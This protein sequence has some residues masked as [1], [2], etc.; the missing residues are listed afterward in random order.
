MILS[1]PE[2]SLLN[3]NNDPGR[4]LAKF[5]REDLLYFREMSFESSKQQDSIAVWLVG[6][7]TASIALIVSQAGKF[8]PNLQPVLKITV[9]CLSATI[10]FGLLFRIFHLFL[11]D[12]EH[13]D[14]RGISGFL[15]AYSQP[16]T[17]PIEL[18]EDLS[19]E[20]IAEFLYVH[21]GYDFRHYLT[22]D[23]DTEFWRD[24]YS[25]LA[26][27]WNQSHKDAMES[28]FSHIGRAEGL[29]EQ[30]VEQKLKREDPARGIRKRR[31]KRLCKALYTFM[32][33]SFTVSVLII[34]FSFIKTDFKTN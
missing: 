9:G 18:P 16:F 32:C 24:L 19:A 20:L 14:F 27:L 23:N 31:L 3:L 28:I 33:I 17:T 5:L 12:K 4:A 34:S 13:S 26:K 30:E 15:A 8:S 1:R 21:M 10:I 29:S 22:F 11:Q 7:S 6:M 2:A 25:R